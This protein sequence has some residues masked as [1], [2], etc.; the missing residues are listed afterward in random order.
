MPAWQSSSRCRRPSCPR[1]DMMPNRSLI[2]ALLVLRAGPG[3]SHAAFACKAPII[4]T[5][6][7]RPGWGCFFISPFLSFRPDCWGLMFFQ[8]AQRDRK[9]RCNFVGGNARDQ[10]EKTV[11]PLAPQFFRVIL[12]FSQPP[13]RGALPYRC[14]H[15]G[16][17]HRRGSGQTLPT[18]FSPNRGIGGQKRTRRPRSTIGVGGATHLHDQRQQCFVHAPR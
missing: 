9:R 18:D 15:T 4:G 3:T 17:L 2:L 11:T 6:F 8:Q 14:V 16:C 10:K 7:L 1:A 12:E 5:K 13:R